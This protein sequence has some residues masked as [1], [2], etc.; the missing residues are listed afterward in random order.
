[1]QTD[2]KYKVL[3]NQG[4]IF[5]CD[6]SFSFFLHKV[7][8][9]L[10]LWGLSPLWTTN[11]KLWRKKNNTLN[12]YLCWIPWRWWWSQ[13]GLG[14]NF[15]T[16]SWAHHQKMDVNLINSLG[17]KDSDT[18]VRSS[19]ICPITMILGNSMFVTR[20]IWNNL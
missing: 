20:N 2:P 1:M 8:T 6:S 10:L 15:S 3:L 19:N 18:P 14:P 7:N 11:S 4:L 17:E 16:Q 12:Y 9:W 13:A 5:F